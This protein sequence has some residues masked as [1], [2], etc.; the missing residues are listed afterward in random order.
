MSQDT[1]MKLQAVL[2]FLQLVNA[3]IATM[4]IPPIIPVLVGAAAGSIQV[5]LQL[6]GNK[7]TPPPP[8][9]SKN[10]DSK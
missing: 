7:S 1:M 5:Y 3:G 4:H 10:G 6:A 8:P 9:N 2:A